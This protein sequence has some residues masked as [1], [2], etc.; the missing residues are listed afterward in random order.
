MYVISNDVRYWMCNNWMDHFVICDLSSKN[1]CVMITDTK[2]LKSPVKLISKKKKS[3]WRIS[4]TLNTILVSKEV[5]NIL[6]WDFG[7]SERKTSGCTGRLQ[8]QPPLVALLTMSW[9]IHH[10][11]ISSGIYR[12]I[13]LDIFNSFG[14]IWKIL[15]K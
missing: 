12:D 11:A 10:S 3:G 15:Q 6:K 14:Y 1:E 5:W 7:K 9:L 4:Y 8:I 13:V 2:W